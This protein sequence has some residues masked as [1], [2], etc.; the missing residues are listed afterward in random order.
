MEYPIDESHTKDEGFKRLKYVTYNFTLATFWTT[1][2]VRSNEID[3]I[4]PTNNGLFNLYLDEYDESWVNK[5][6]DFDYIILSSGHWF[7]RPMVFY[8]GNKVIGCNSC[9]QPNLTELPVHYGYKKVFR[10]AL[11]AINNMKNFKGTTFLRTFAPSHFDGGTWDNGGKCLRTRPFIRNQT[12]LA[13]DHREMYVSQ[14]E[15]FERA[16]QEGE[17]RGLKFKLVDIT[18]ASLLRPDG[19]PSTYGHWKH[20]KVKLYNDCVHWCL[21]GPIDTWN[22]FLLEMVKRER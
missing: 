19:H 1:H 10:T 5:V 13:K 20:E 21:P 12:K 15:E 17:K 16:R 2:L 9:M 18:L 7:F 4:G 22:D 3:R 11:K 6:E 14:I 8:E